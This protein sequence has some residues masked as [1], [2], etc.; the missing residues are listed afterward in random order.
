ML[1]T[2]GGRGEMVGPYCPVCLTHADDPTLINLPAVRDD[3]AV[4]EP[5]RPWTAWLLFV[6]F[7]ILMVVGAAVALVWHVPNLWLLLVPMACVTLVCGL[8]SQA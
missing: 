7:P 6:A 3:V 4:A 2:N 8:R 1:C 5:E